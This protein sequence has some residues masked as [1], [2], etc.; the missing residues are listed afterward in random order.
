MNKKV[1]VRFA[2]SP[3]GYLHIGGLRTALYNFLYAKKHK[4]DYFLRIEDTD[5]KR[6]V[7][8]AIKKLID[9][10]DWAGL[11][12]N[13][14]VFVNE[15]GD[16]Y[17]KGEYKPYI[18]SKRLEIYKKYAHELVEKKKAYYCFCTPERL[19]S[20]RAVQ[21]KARLAPAY[22]KLCLKE[23][24]REEAE[25]KIAN[26]EKCV[27]RFD[28]PE[29]GET[30]FEDVVRGKVKFTNKNLDDFVI[31]KSDGYPT[32]HLAHVVDDHLMKTTLVLRGEEWLS[33]TPKHL[34]LYQAF[35]WNPPQYGHLCVILNK[36]TKK[37]LSKRDGDVSV[38]DFMKKGYLPEAVVNFI[39]LL[40]WNPK[41]EQEFFTLEELIEEFDISKLNKSGAI[42]DRD[43]LDWMNS[44]YLRKKE[45]WELIEPSRPYL[46]EDE[47]KLSDEYIEKIVAVEKERIKKLSDIAEN[48]EVYLKK[49]TYEKDLLKWKD[50]D[51]NNL[52]IS[53]KKALDIIS[54]VEESKWTLENLKNK[55]LAAADPENRGE[56]LWPLRVA[57][58]GK[59]KSP[60]PWEVAWAVGK[61][62]TLFRIQKAIEKIK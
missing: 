23:I 36:N 56:L 43:K 35:D 40:G 12:H 7:P 62:E 14:G 53:L 28:V 3:T 57:L 44:I 8:G 58:T 45:D 24:S 59:E 13:E 5:Q 38:G 46:E 52:A 55:L 21:E 19:D 39:A 4:G 42:F 32:Y 29:T 26:G 1:R 22:D 15:K 61:R 34:L 50:M 49:P 18:Q 2:P 17:E 16:I 31:L 6:V 33:S 25:K 10:L 47:E 51:N 41:T 60:S 54:S 48:K 37:K 30:E 27:I 11:K 20:L 9:S